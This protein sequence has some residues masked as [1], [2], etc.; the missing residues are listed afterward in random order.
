[1]TTK[2]GRVASVRGQG[3]Q[4]EGAASEANAPVPPPGASLLVCIGPN[5]GHRY[6]IG[7][8]RITLGRAAGCDV[9]IDDERVAELHASIV[10]DGH[11][12]RLVDLSVSLGT[13]L[14]AR[15][16]DDQPLHDGD[17][18]QLGMSVFRYIGSEAIVAR[19]R[20]A[21]QPVLTESQEIQGIHIQDMP[22]ASGDARV[23][24]PASR[25]VMDA[26]DAQVA[27]DVWRLIE[28]LRLLADDEG[29]RARDDEDLSFA[30]M[31]A[32]AR[33]VVAFF[34]P[35]RFIIVGCAAV[36][37]TVGLV[38][39]LVFP[40]SAAAFFDVRLHSKASANPLERYESANVEFFRSAPTTFRSTGLI[41]R[42]LAALGE[43]E[44]SA[45]RLDVVQRN[46]A[47]DNTG[48]DQSS[49]TW[50]GRFRAETPERSLGFLAQHVELYLHAEIDKT[51]KIIKAQVEFL[52]QQLDDTEKQLRA[53][54]SSLLS[55][56][57][58]NIDGL[59]EQARQ[60]YDYL[61]EL[62]KKESDLANEV[63]RLEAEAAVDA[64]RLATE[65]PLVESRVLATRPYQQAIVDVNRQ[66]A[67]ARSRG[68]AEDHP[69]VGQLRLKLDEL[70]RLAS[71]AE[72]S[73]DDTEVE[74]SRNP[75][76]ESTVERLNR[77]R[78]A[79]ASTREERLRLR[80]DQ[81][82]IKAIVDRLP[83]LEAEYA[84]LTRSYDATK[85]LHTRIFDQLKTAQL[86]YELE[87]A[88]A[89]ARYEI[90]TAPRLEHVSQLKTLVKRSLL[91][92][93]VGVVVGL[94]GAT[95]LQARRAL[96]QIAV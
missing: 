19:G 79:A 30:D 60:Y 14:N 27:R 67:E 46:L 85:Q 58:E 45:E 40:P 51:L 63:N 72:R 59:P 82:R 47:F 38:S 81:Q 86:Q 64:R 6:S 4:A 77:L 87:K 35:H 15:P 75:I 57:K 34:W 54:E 28:R 36:G 96:G 66:I 13:L 42:T 8:G 29:S 43:P 2:R 95:A 94:L 12:H 53:T 56:K 39:V 91:L 70:R 76:Y 89:S 44:A 37:L 83:K 49:E 71:D 68:L 17:L 24:A 9:V 78:V 84:E 73:T 93:L 48:T 69:D 10:Q 21:L 65:A 74:R 90:I 11:G 62:Q 22:L 92:A 55:F 50:T 88:S 1:M 41:A 23:D 80:Q 61:F 16:V 7:S 31:V 18:V 3:E 26:G 20:S 25:E 32:Q 33:R 52:Q 5:V